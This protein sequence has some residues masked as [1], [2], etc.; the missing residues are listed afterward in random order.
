MPDFQDGF[1]SGRTCIDNLISLSLSL[2]L[3]TLLSTG[4]SQWRFWILRAFEN[5]IPAILVQDLLDMSLPWNFCRFIAN[6]TKERKVFFTVNGEL[7]GP[8]HS[9]KGNPQG[10]T[11]SPILFDI[12]LKHR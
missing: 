1:R 2:A 8:F 3:C 7:K 9:Y 5:V 6:F 11:L 4:I 10:S 12:Y